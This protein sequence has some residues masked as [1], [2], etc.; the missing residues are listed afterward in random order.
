MYD[1]KKIAELKKFNKSLIFVGSVMFFGT[2]IIKIW[3]KDT[4][5]EELESIT[6]NI[7]TIPYIGFLWLILGLYISSKLVKKKQSKD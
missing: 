6:K 2:I 3:G 4:S 1:E 5:Y 7:F